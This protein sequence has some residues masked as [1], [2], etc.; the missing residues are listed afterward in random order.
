[1][2]Y[3]NSAI[4]GERTWAALLEKGFVGL[5]R[6]RCKAKRHLVLDRRL[7]SRIYFTR[8]LYGMPLTTTPDMFWSSLGMTNCAAAEAARNAKQLSLNQSI[9]EVMT[10]CL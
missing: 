8:V 5:T 6:V 3:N 9:M 10:R 4:S 2:V 1:M 7:T